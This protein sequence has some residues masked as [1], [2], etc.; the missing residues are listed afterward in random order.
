MLRWGGGRAEWREPMV[1]RTPRPAATTHQTLA[2]CQSRCWS[3]AGPRWVA[4]HRH[5]TLTT[6]DGVSRLTLVVRQCVHP[7]CPPFHRPYRPEAEGGLALPHGEF[8]RD[9]IALVGTLR[10]AE[11]R[12]IPEI[13]QRLPARG[14]AIAER[15]VTNL[16]DRYEELVALHLSDASRR[17]ARRPPR[18]R[19]IL[20]LDGIA[21]GCRPCG[22]LG[23]PRLPLRRGPA[24]P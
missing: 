12:S 10:D 19:V 6:L 18:G 17:P 20:A 11:H 3:C 2:P 13:H 8:G 15:S 22:A 24:G 1:R 7:T 14:L 4:Y 23:A 16:L 21:T 5:R 9:I